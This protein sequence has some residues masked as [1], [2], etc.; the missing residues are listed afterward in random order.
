MNELDWSHA[1]RDVPSGGLSTE[2]RATPQQCVAVATLLD[3]PGVE[4]LVASYRIKSAGG[5]QY[6]LAGDIEAQVVQAC[7]VTLEPVGSTIKAP[8]EVLLVP[9]ELLAAA[10]SG[11][12][13]DAAGDDL[14]APMTETIE[15]GVIDV[16]RIVY[17]ELASQLDPYPRRPDASFAWTDERASAAEVHPFAELAKLRGTKKPS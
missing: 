8:F 17:E 2:R 7:V 12:D 6:R 5:G 16:G 4:S 1:V 14:E 10:A 9:S 15:N 13:D 3:I 11:K